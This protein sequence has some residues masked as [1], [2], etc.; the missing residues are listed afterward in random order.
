MIARILTIKQDRLIMLLDGFVLL[1]I[2][3]GFIVGELISC[4]SRSG[5]VNELSPDSTLC[6]FSERDQ[7]STLLI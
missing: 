2:T 1:N 5:E 7:I 3:V 6:Q 4:Q